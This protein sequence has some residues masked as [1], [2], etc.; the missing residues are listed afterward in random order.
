[1]IGRIV[2]PLI[3]LAMALAVPT[4][5]LRWISIEHSCCCPDPDLCQCPHDPP[6]QQPT[7]RVCHS[8]DHVIASPVAPV[9]VAPVVA[10]ADA[11]A[12]CAPVAAAPLAAP[13]APP[14]PRRP[15]APS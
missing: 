10:L 6:T 7:L 1:V 14:A 9:F 2:A 5:Q 8:T 15:D 4:S 11:P 3:A 12:T 13:H